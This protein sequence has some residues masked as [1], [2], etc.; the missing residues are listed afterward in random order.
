MPDEVAQP[1][2]V[3]GV[4]QENAG[5]GCRGSL[6]ALSIDRKIE[7]RIVIQLG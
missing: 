2:T 7:Y 5:V 3:S 6:P 1:V 4:E